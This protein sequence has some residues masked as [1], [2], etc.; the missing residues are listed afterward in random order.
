MPFLTPLFIEKLVDFHS[1]LTSEQKTILAKK[2]DKI[3]NHEKNV[4]V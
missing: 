2:I 4:A 1:S 3:I